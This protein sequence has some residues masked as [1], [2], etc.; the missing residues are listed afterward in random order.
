MSNKIRILMIEDSLDDC[1]LI[2]YELKKGGIEFDL[3][4]LQEETSF[5]NELQKNW[6]LIISDYAMP[7]FNG[8]EALSIL[9]KTDID[10]PFLIVSGTIG[11]DLAAEAMGQGANDYI[12]KNR[13][14]RLV[15]AV[16]RELAALDARKKKKEAEIN[17]HN[18]QDQVRHLQKIEALGL[19]AS[20]IAHDFNNM[21]SVMSIYIHKLRESQDP[22]VQKYT[23][24]MAHVHEKSVALTKQLLVFSKKKPSVPSQIDLN[25]MIFEM[26]EMIENILGP[27]IFLNLELGPT[28][29]SIYANKSQVEQVLMNLIINAKDAMSQ[30]G[31]L[32][33]K[34]QTVTFLEV[35]NLTTGEIPPGEYLQVDITD[36]G[37]GMSSEII[38]KIFE[39]F[40]TTKPIDKG[41]GLGLSIVHG[42]VQQI[43]G[44]IQIQSQVGDGTTFTVYFPVVRT[45]SES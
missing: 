14:N 20:G 36:T 35:R 10:I 2:T 40:F 29:P 38:N 41:S 15:P 4:M 7:N 34:S 45:P 39:P 31:M 11:E 21:L 12:L 28:L 37:A 43:Q 9:K 23:E 26:K 22:Q 6:D 24:K 18:S 17:F 25:S 13:L 44:G 16:Q 42:I 19:L 8:L 5:R 1:E 33:V 3:T 27:E 30:G 32:T